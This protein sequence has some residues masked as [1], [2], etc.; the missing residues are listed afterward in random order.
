MIKHLSQIL[1]DNFRIS[2]E[3]LDEAQRISTEKGEKTR[4]ILLRKKTITESQLLEA[5]SIQY[6]IP[7]RPDL[8]FQNIGQDI[9][10]QIPIQFLKKHVMVPLTA[11]PG[12]FG[13]EDLSLQLMILHLFKLLMTYWGF[14]N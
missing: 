5:L 7:F 3:E 8:P 2:K 4:E 10:D 13:I 9:I 12:E 6:N 11:N 1:S 14:S